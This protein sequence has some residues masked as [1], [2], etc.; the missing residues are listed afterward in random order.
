MRSF[1]GG[2]FVSS[3]NHQSTCHRNIIHGEQFIVYK[4]DRYLCFGF[5]FSL[6]S[7]VRIAPD[8]S[9]M[10]KVGQEIKSLKLG[11]R[12]R[13]NNPGLNRFKLS[14]YS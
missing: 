11:G 14:G 7:L 12:K 1:P 6:I 3:F 4:L 9:Q 10:A 2:V 5:F 13:S 8:L